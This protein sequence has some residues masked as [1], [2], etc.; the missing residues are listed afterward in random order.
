MRVLLVGMILIALPVSAGS[1]NPEPNTV[2]TE[3]KAET[4][5]ETKAEKI[6]ARPSSSACLVSEELVQD[7]EAREKRIAEKEQAL[8]EKEQD[9]EAQKQAIVVEMKKLETQRNELQGIKTQKLA[10]QEEQMNK[11]VETF[12]SMSPKAAAQVIAKVDEELATL[13]LSKVSSQK[14]AK[15]LSAMD[16]QKASRLSEMIAYGTGTSSQERGKTDAAH[17]TERA[18]ASTKR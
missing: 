12:E 9:L 14:T 2:A 15:I 11:L 13:A 17:R 8:Q 3:A 10:A 16:A 7:I 18:P 6:A 1:S 5:S 4:K